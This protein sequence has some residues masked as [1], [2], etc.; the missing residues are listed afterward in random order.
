MTFELIGEGANN[1][2]PGDRGRDCRQ[3][4]FQFLKMF[5][6]RFKLVKGIPK[7]GTGRFLNSILGD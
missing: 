3:V 1:R 7:K 6:K 2:E 5:F 4:D